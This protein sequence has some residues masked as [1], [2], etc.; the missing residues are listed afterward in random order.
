MVRLQYA[1]K[2]NGYVGSELGQEGFI[3]TN[4]GAVVAGEPH[5]AASW[6]PVN[7]HPTDKATYDIS[8]TVPSAYQ[9]LSNGVLASKTVNGAA[10][11]GTG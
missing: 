1:G 5:V 2:P 7:D 6:F 4:H 10:P 3:P 8:I 11:P 9:A